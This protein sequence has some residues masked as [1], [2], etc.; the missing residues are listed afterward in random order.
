MPKTWLG[1]ID[2]TSKR[3]IEEKI[4]NLDIKMLKGLGF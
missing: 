2:G 3:F 1:S 4:H